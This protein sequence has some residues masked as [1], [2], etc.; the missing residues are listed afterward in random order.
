MTLIQRTAKDGK[1]E[2]VKTL[3]AHGANPDNASGDRDALYYAL[4]E[5]N[6]REMVEMLVDAGATVRVE[7]DTELCAGGWTVGSGV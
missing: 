4:Y 5:H 2:L 3:L 6:S 1:V 7:H